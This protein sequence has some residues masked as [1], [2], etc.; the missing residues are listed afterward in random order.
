[1][2]PQKQVNSK[3]TIMTDRHTF[4]EQLLSRRFMQLFLS[5]VLVIFLQA[6]F[7]PSLL[8]AGV[9]ALLYLNM[10]LVAVSGIQAG[11]WARGVIFLV[12][13][14][15]SVTRVMAARE[16]TPEIHL[17]SRVFSALLLALSVFHI[18]R[19]IVSRE[20]VTADTLFASAVVYIL[21]AL[22]F[23]N[24]YAIADAAIANSLSFPEHFPRT[25]GHSGEIAYIYFSFV[26]IA[27]LGYGDVLPTVPLTQ[28][29]VSVQA[30]IG[31]FYVAVVV[32]WLV[33]LFVAHKNSGD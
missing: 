21:I 27:T 2:S 17:L 31:Q 16:Y 1:M 20:R 19:L 7:K 10:M 25:D 30:V 33:S 15:C 3:E 32:A 11:R 5:L 23:A 18:L 28:M 26:T 12:W 29:M 24:L 14:A 22:M 9:A 13:L 8:L 4:S 6:A